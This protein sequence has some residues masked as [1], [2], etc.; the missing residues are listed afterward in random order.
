[1]MSSEFFDNFLEVKNDFRDIGSS[2]GILLPTIPNECFGSEIKVLGYFGPG[3]LIT[4]PIFALFKGLFSI[5]TI[6]GNHFVEDH[7]KRVD[8]GLFGSLDGDV[9]FIG[10]NFCRRVHA[11]IGIA[12]DQAEVFLKT[13]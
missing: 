13:E 6:F 3:L 12:G 11:L 1:M 9:I 10:E 7:A 5:N 8:I 4:E 2:Y